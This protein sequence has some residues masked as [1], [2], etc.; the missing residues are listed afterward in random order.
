MRYEFFVE[1][2]ETERVK[3]LSVWS[4]F[5]DE[6][7]IARPKMGDPRGRSVREQMVH[8]CVSEDLWCRTMLGVDVGAPPLPASETRLEFIKRY[9]EDSGKRLEVFRAKDEAWW[10]GET[11]F[12][13]GAIARVGDDAAHYAHVTSSRA[14]DGD[15]AYAG[16]RSAQQLRANGGHRGGLM[17]NHAPT[18]YAYAL[19]RKV[20]GS[21]EAVAFF[22]KT[23]AF[24]IH[25]HSPHAARSQGLRLAVSTITLPF[26]AASCKHSE[27]STV[28]RAPWF[29][30]PR[31]IRNSPPIC[32]TRDRIIP[33]PSPLRSVASK[34]SGKPGPSSETDSA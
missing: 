8:Q 29:L 12:F 32:L 33:I 20:F 15:A 3:V 7:L 19:A 6:D 9:A 31:P 23:A 28:N 16:P 14:A 1:T 30:S 24:R 21:N 34:P 4:E 13:D 5:H 11:K 25:C 2:Y 22:L 26:V 10:E 17:Q 27:N 18:I